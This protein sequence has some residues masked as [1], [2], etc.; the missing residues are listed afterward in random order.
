MILKRKVYSFF[1]DKDKDGDYDFDDVKLQYKEDWQKPQFGHPKT[2]AVVGAGVTGLS[3]YGGVKAGET[4]MNNKLA[5]ESLSKSKKVLINKINDQIKQGRITKEQAKK[6]LSNPKKL[7]S[8]LKKHGNLDEIIR[9]TSKTAG[10]RLKK[11]KIV[12]GVA[13]G[14]VPAIG[15]IS[16]IAR[17]SEKEDIL[18]YGPRKIEVGQVKLVQK[19]KKKK[20]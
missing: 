7:E 9:Q 18:K 1:K 6:A 16:A 15:S 12:G 3:A 4:Y 13:A 5:K 17:E 10:P 2:A 19:S 8:L 20:K 11:A 14:L